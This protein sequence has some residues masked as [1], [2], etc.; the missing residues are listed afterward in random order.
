MLLLPAIDIRDGRCVRLLRGDF[1]QETRYD[2][3]PVELARQYANLGAKWLHV[4]D[5][6]GAASG[7]L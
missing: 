4:V 7:V 3:D 5:L 6:D 2:I 1:D